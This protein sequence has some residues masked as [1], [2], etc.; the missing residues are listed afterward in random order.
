MPDETVCPKCKS[1]NII[2]NVRVMDRDH[3]SGDS[4]ASLS[5]VVYENP[6]AMIFKGAHEGSLSAWVCGECGFTQLFLD[7]PRELYAIY[8]ESRRNSASG[9]GE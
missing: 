7:N 8:E 1:E 9:A 4:G 5:L 2:R 3:Y 6:D